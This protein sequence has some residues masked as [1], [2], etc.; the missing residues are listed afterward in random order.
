MEIE[1]VRE[2]TIAPMKHNHFAEIISIAHALPQW[3]TETGIRNMMVDLKHQ[4]GFVI[5]GSRGDVLGFITY[6]VNQ[7]VAQI[8]W[9]A[10]NPE[11]HRKSI[12]QKLLMGLEIYLVQEDVEDLQVSTLGDSVDYEPYA[13]TRNFYRKNG[14]VDYNRVLHPENPECE[15][16]LIMKKVLR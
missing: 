15:E 1:K 16:E 12:G 9:M 7:G 5:Q 6:F 10:V 4:K 2:F 11:F 3:F 8:G 13:R 14:F